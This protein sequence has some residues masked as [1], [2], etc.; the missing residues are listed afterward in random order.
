MALLPQTEVQLPRARG[1]WGDGN[2]QPSL[3]MWKWCSDLKQNKTLLSM[4]TYRWFCIQNNYIMHPIDNL[5]MRLKV[6][7]RCWDILKGIVFGVVKFDW[8][9]YFVHLIYI[10]RMDKMPETLH[11]VVFILSTCRQGMRCIILKRSCILSSHLFSNVIQFNTATN[12]SLQNNDKAESTSPR[13]FQQTLK[14]SCRLQVP[15]LNRS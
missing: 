1:I 4:D 12:T 6:R 3:Y 5:F 14:P 7:E 15:W 10:N 9:W 11:F 13:Q 2:D 8:I